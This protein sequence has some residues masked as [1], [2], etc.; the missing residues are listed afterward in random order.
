M[1]QC[2]QI[3]GKSMWTKKAGVLKKAL[4]IEGFDI[5]FV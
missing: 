1:N 3:Y 5:V 2:Q 4:K